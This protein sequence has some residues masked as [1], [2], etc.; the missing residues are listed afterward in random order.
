LTVRS[1][2]KKG[3]GEKGFLSRTWIDM[4]PSLTSGHETQRGNRLGGGGK[5]G[6]GGSKTQREKEKVAAVTSKPV[7]KGRST[8]RQAGEKKNGKKDGCKSRGGRLGGLALGVKNGA[9]SDTPCGTGAG[10]PHSETTFFTPRGRCKY[11][12]E[13]NVLGSRKLRGY[14]ELGFC[15]QR[16]C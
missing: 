10:G 6:G 2:G 3:G 7:S 16:N 12:T 13:E 11:T 9:V 5:T 4:G 8:L 15:A 1:A 14:K